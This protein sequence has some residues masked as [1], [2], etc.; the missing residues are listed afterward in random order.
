ML[1]S[2]GS[3]LRTWLS[4]FNIKQITSIVKIILHW[5]ILWVQ[6]FQCY[7]HEFPILQFFL[8]QCFLPFSRRFRDQSSRKAVDDQHR[9]TRGYSSNSPSHS[10]H[11]S[12]NVNIRWSVLRYLS[13]LLSINDSE[14]QFPQKLNPW[15]VFPRFIWRTT[16]HINWLFCHVSCDLFRLRWRYLVRFVSSLSS[17]RTPIESGLVILYYSVLVK[18]NWRTRERGS[19]SAQGQ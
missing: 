3:Q 7:F 12:Q 9:V 11:S 10:T 4:L 16:K 2:D 1:L 17:S 5:T 13:E 18:L 6:Y 14:Y 15:Y 19:P 8:H